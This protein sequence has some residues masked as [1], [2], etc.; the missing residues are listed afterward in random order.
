MVTP[1]GRGQDTDNIA[2]FSVN[3][4][5]DAFA[6]AH[7]PQFVAPGTELPGFTVRRTPKKTYNPVRLWRRRQRLKRDALEEAQHLRRWHG[8]LALSVAREKL[9]RPGRT[10]WG[11]TVLTDAIRLLADRRI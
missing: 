5:R 6:P 4:H 3:S 2:T 8:E 10:T 9:T 1:I 7:S 11:R